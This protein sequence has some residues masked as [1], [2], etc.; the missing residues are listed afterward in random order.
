MSATD[1]KLTFYNKEYCQI[2]FSAAITGPLTWPLA[3][4][5]IAKQQGNRAY[6]FLSFLRSQGYQR[7]FSGCVPY[8]SYKLF[9]IGSQRGVQTPV[10][11]YLNTEQ[12]LINNRWI[13]YVV[14][15]VASGVI[16]G[17]IVTPIEQLKISFANKNFNSYKQTQQFFL[18]DLKRVGYLLSG[19]RATIGRNVVF[20]S[21]NAILYN[22][23]LANTTFK[24]DRKNAIYM[25]AVNCFA[26]VTTAVIDYPLDVIKTRIQSATVARQVVSAPTPSIWST[27]S[28]MVQTEGW[29]SLYCGL[30]HKI[31]L[32]ASV[33][34][35]YGVSFG[36][37]GSVL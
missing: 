23:I 1:L 10:L 8:S 4:E 9:G 2:L 15:G 31:S 18:T 36:A 3:A 33:W 16:G 11:E 37:L 5:L 28:V 22:G 19:A 27:G 12:D 7:A 14:A 34:L 26:G 20:D 6:N 13:Q 35:V 30:R 25:G 24:I 17:F 21:I 29:R 32:Y